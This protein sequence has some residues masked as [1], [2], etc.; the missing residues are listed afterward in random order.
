MPAGCMHRANLQGRPFACTNLQVMYCHS[1]TKQ[2]CSNSEPLLRSA[3]AQSSSLLCAYR[4]PSLEN[5]TMACC[6]LSSSGVGAL[7]SLERLTCLDLV[8]CVDGVTPDAMRLLSQV[9]HVC[10]PRTVMSKIL[11]GITFMMHRCVEAHRVFDYTH[12]CT[13]CIWY[14][15]RIS[16]M[17]SVLSV[18]P[19]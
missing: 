1:Q 15:L 11:T 17:L 8:G 3:H 7:G 13:L 9:N 16:C 19:C 10:N 12:C 5:L 14:V 18:T 2:H 6:K 4:L